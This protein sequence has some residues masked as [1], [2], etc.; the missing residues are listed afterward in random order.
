MT[1]KYTANDIRSLRG[2]ALEEIL[3]EAKERFPLVSTE[4]SWISEATIECRVKTYIMAGLLP[5][6]FHP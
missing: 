4:P 6:D 5:S 2:I 3:M 1:V